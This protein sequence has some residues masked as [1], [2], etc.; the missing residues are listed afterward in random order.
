MNGQSGTTSRPFRRTSSSSGRDELAAEAP[1]FAGRVDLGVH[2]RDP[3]A[4]LAAVVG[5]DADAPVSE[6]KLVLRRLGHVDDLGVLRRGRDLGLLGGLEELDELA[7][8]IRFARRL[9]VDE[10]APV[11][12]GVLPA[13]E[14]AQ[15]PVDRARPAEEAAVLG[16]QRGDPVG[17][18]NG[19]QRSPLL[20]PRLD[21][22]RDE[23]EAELGEDLAHRARERAPLGLVQRQH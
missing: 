22:A 23:V 8:G 9:V 7:D 1:S 11:L 18:R 5:G 19:P 17:A 14:L 15:V 12:G 13:L 2:E 20:G 21:L 4:V 16:L 10:A 6:P 3:V